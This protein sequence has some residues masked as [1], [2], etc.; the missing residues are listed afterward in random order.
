MLKATSKGIFITLEGG[1]GSGKSTL[2]HQLQDILAQRGYEVIKTREPGGSKLGEKMR[3]WLLMQDSSVSIGKQAELLLFLAARAQ[4]IEELILPALNAGKVVLCDRYNDSTIAYQGGARG[5]EVSYV[6]EL[7]RLVCGQ[8]QPDLTLFLDVDPAIG[9][10]RTQGLS[11]EQA[12][13]GQLDRIEAEKLD[14]HLQVQ[15]TF[16]WLWKQEPKRIWHIDAN[17]SQAEVKQEALKAI[18]TILFTPTF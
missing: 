13:S 17:L 15:E 9:L 7:C 10:L 1:E 3:E 12:L 8:V 16:H 14:F 18:D 2:L 6:Q 5:L 4:H 11:K